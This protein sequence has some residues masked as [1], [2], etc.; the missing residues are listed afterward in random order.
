MFNQHLRVHSIS[1]LSLPFSGTT[2]RWYVGILN[3]SPYYLF[4]AFDSSTVFEIYPLTFPPIFFLSFFF[5]SP[6]QRSDYDTPV[7]CTLSCLKCSLSLSLFFFIQQYKNKSKKH[8]VCVCA[9]TTDNMETHEVCQ[10]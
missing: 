4:V 3:G 10:Q 7:M 8:H 9:C 2:H 5:S 1:V 6:A